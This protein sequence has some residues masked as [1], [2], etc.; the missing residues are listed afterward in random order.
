MLT[1]REFILKTFEIGGFGALAMMGLE[2]EARSWG[3][4]PAAVST[5]A[6]AAGAG[7]ISASA[8]TFICQ[9]DDPVSGANETGA[10]LG[11]S[12]AN[13]VLTDRTGTIAGSVDEESRVIVETQEFNFTQGLCEAG[14]A[15]GDKWTIALKVS[16]LTLGAGDVFFNVIQTGNADQIAL[17]QDA[18]SN[19]LLSLKVDGVWDTSCETANVL[20]AASSTPIWIV[21]CAPGGAN[22]ARA[23]WTTTAPSLSGGYYWPWS[24]FA[25][26]N[27]DICDNTTGDFTGETLDTRMSFC[28]D[29]NGETSMLGNFY[30]AVLS[31]L[32]LVDI[33]A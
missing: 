27:R 15:A 21:V 13:L 31:K 30:T 18:Q 1:R 7:G 29:G 12:G 14:L 28:G 9:I 19:L 32:C 5:A 20:P 10:G 16:D 2:R 23:G 25:A 33:A 24:A 3:I 17:T 22:K 11:L 26:G 6:G 4:Q 8:N